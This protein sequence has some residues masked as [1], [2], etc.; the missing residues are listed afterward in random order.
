MSVA[1][2]NMTIHPLALINEIP[3][4][5]R[6]FRGELPDLLPALHDAII[7]ELAYIG[8]FAVVYRGIDRPTTIGMRSLIEAGT[9]IGHDVLI[10]DNVE[11]ASNSGIGGYAI[12]RDGVKI[13]T[14]ATVL[15]YVCVGKNAR[16]G[17]GAVVTRHVPAGETW[18]GVPA[19]Q[20]APRSS[21][22]NPNEGKLRCGCG[23]EAVWDGC[24]HHGSDPVC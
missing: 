2:R 24:P 5:R 14:G 19:E 9:I 12:I 23:V 1:S 18:A 8:P 7:E 21:P 13:G 6:L 15:P 10:G 16:I 3:F 4:D 11:I 20:I 17:A 22:V